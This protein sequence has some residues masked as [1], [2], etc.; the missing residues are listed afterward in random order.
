MATVDNLEVK[1]HASATQAVNA[2][3]KLSNKLGTLSKTLQG[4][5]SNGITKFAQGMNQLAQGMNAIKNVKMPD[6]NRAAKGIKQFENINSGK[7]TAVANSISPLASSISV[8]GNMQFSN[9]GLTNFINSITRLSNSNISGM[10]TNA[11]GQLGNAIVGLS[12]TL[13][14]AQN[15]STNVIQLTNA[16]GRLANAGQKASVVSATLPQLSVALRNLLN[17]MALAPQL[18]AGTIQ[19]TTALGNLASVG[20]KA[21]QTAGGLGVLAAELKKF[22]QVMATAPQV[23]QNVIQMT[24]ALANLAAQGSRTA[25]AS[26]G[27]Q[28]SFS[29]MG[30]SAKNA[31]K[32]IWSLAS[33]VGKLYATFWAAQRVLSGFKKAIDISSDLTEVQNVVVNTFGQYTD[34]LEQFS[35]TSIKMYGMSELSA[36]Q[37]AGRFQAMGLA[38]GAPVKDMSDMSIQLTALSADLASFYNIS[39][40]ESSRKLWS[41]FTGETEPMRAFGIDLTNATLKEYAMKKGLD[42]NISSMSQL[43]KTML[44]YQYVMDNTKNVQGDFARTSQTW[45]NQLR[46]L[47]EQIKA[48]AGVWGNAFVNMLK[49]L[50]QA[51]NKALSAVYTF[52][53]KVV[54]ALGAIFGWKLEIQKGSI[55]D[56]FEGAAGAADDM[57]SGT[58][59]AAKAAKDLKTH[60]LEIDELNVVEPDNGTGANGGNGSGGG[61]GVGG[62]GGDNGLKYQIKETEGLYKSSIK[63]LNQLGKYI[64]NSL[65]K[66]M[67]S[68]KWGKIYKKAE[69]FGKGLADFLNGLISPRLF[70]DLGST[71][72]GAINTALSAGNTFAINFDWRNLGKS[73]ISSITGFLNTWDAGLT[74]ATLSNFAIGICKTIV[75]AFETIKQ[76]GIW[77]KLG[78]K[79]VDFIC[80]I[81]WGSLVWNLGSLIITMAKEIPKI[82]MQIFEGVGQ[83]IIDK[84]FGEGAYSKIS[85][86]K[87][88]KGVKK[89][90][91]YIIA[92]MNLIVDIIN[93]IKTGLGR[94][95]PYLDKINTLL[96]PVLN[97]LSNILDTIYSVISKIA[98][99][100]SSRIS[101]ALK[102]IKTILSPIL[103]VMLAVNSVI[104]Q[105]IG[106]W[107]IK[108]IADISAKVQIAW[109]IIKPI[110]NSITKK[111]KTLWD[112]LKKIADKLGNVAKF[113]MKTSPIVGLSGIIKSKFNIDTTTNGKSDK[114]YKKL[115]KSVRGAISIFDG[116]N[117]DYNVDT[118]VNDKKTKNVATIK[119]IAKLWADTWKDK[120]AKY[121]AQTATNG[122]LTPTNSVLFGIFG[123]FSAAWKDKNATFSANTAVNGTKTADKSKVAVISNAF[124]RVWKG[125]ETKLNANTAINGVKASSNRQIASINRA[126][127]GA[128]KDKNATFSANTAVNGTL[129]K[130]AQPVKTVN[131]LMQSKFTGKNVTYNIQTQDDSTLKKLGENAASQI[132]MGMSDKEIKFRIKNAPDPLK[133]AMSGSFSFMPTYATGGFPE[134]G[135]FRASQGEIMGKFDNGKSVVANNEQ[136]TAGIA[137]GVRQAVDDV[138]APYL[139][140]IA[141]NTRETADKDTSINIDG[142]T[143]VSETDRRRSRNGYQFTTA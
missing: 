140:Q 21:T 30:S 81:N 34:K 106:N 33:A 56:D 132:Y 53:E 7:L 13:Q 15:V 24:H 40:E 78:Q 61:S 116:K 120:N 130:T 126:F 91:E 45:A 12:S 136:I 134:D 44:R 122:R 117:V 110:L 47:Q 35:K 137:N 77:Q 60:F 46:I 141:R 4:I 58:K 111:L 6:F 109:D 71:I 88:F 107:I 68:I 36:K 98:S 108:K 3:D 27:I 95:S 22:M 96:N 112:Y 87:L 66:A 20:A 93:K 2:V 62:A 59:K 84:V 75:S 86:S 121:D 31:R 64:S 90:L 85:N 67:E 113:G 11:I 32:H 133:E 119:S 123:R 43:E 9:K 51:L 104:R 41:I 29:G 135:W 70:S 103:T 97:V 102:T 99:A 37:T 54:N 52:S 142:R 8:L 57:A 74:G 138:L 63:N 83:A 139:S 19:M 65:S 38:M 18:S 55:S 82:P 118:S 101:P 105:L 25:S 128:W 26:R 50:V 73:L 10:N 39:Q 69:N 1:I 143:L 89:A 76:D 127:T 94:L 92:P 115:N 28:N 23:S 48:V 125:K 100:M 72:A 16:V 14:G 49:P 5:D 131:D 79:V 80:G 124:T 129:T 17:T 114:D 42:A